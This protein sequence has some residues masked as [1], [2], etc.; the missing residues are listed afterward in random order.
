MRVGF[1]AAREGAW[2]GYTHRVADPPGLRHAVERYLDVA[3]FLG[4]GRTPV[5]FDI[6]VTDADEARADELLAPLKGRPFALLMPGTN[7]PTKRW[8]AAHFTTLATLV[9]SHLSLAPVTA[10][11]ADAA[12]AAAGVPGLNLTNQTTVREL[13]ALLKRA[14]LVVCNDSGPMHLAAALRRP[15]VALFGPT[16]PHRTG[17]FG[18][19]QSVV[20]LDVPC[21]PC[22]SRRC[23]HQTCLAALS[24]GDVLGRCRAALQHG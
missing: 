20:R 19:E 4:C 7:W 11:A 16:D 9:E 5:D 22:L 21:A 2:L 14:A 15:L 12:E 23:A 6:R 13:I 10:G 17:P 8:P 24:P 1:A 18:S 3:D